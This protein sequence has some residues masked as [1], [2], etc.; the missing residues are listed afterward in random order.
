MRINELSKK[1]GVDR[2]TIDYWTNLG[3]I[4]CA[5]EKNGYRNYKKEG[6]EDIR[7]ILILRIAEVKDIEAYLAM[8]KLPKD[9]LE[10]KAVPAIK[11]AMN[12]AFK[13]YTSALAYAKKMGA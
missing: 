2:R 6:E 8:D 12:K 1:Y 9:F 4:R 5:K 10:Q 7:K 13:Q 3:W 11:E